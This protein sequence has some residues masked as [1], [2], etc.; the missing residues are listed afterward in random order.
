MSQTYYGQ[1]RIGDFP[2]RDA[3]VGF[4]RACHYDGIRGRQEEL[5]CQI[6]PDQE[7]ALSDLVDE[8]GG[9]F[10]GDFEVIEEHGKF[11]DI[12]F[13]SR[14]PDDV[15]ALEAFV[16]LLQEIGIPVEYQRGAVR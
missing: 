8:Y 15:E 12:G 7:E 11:I 4:I 1:L 10:L 2:R 16:A 3:L 5:F 9:Q 6:W 14:S 13:E